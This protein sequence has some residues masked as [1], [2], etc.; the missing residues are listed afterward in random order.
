MRLLI[1]SELNSFIR[2]A[3]KGSTKNRNK[4]PNQLVK[5]ECIDR[6]KEF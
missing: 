6:E 4:K 2:G 5:T 3:V 1:K